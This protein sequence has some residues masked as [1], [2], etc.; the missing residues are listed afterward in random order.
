[1]KIEQKYKKYKAIFSCI[2]VVAAI[3]RDV[4]RNYGGIPIP[5]DERIRKQVQWS[6]LFKYPWMME[7]K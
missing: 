1:V 5:F 4:K 6:L 7:N 2:C 3:R